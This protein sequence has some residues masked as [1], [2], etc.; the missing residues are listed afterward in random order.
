MNI[1]FT[2]AVDICGDFKTNFYTQNIAIICRISK[3]FRLAK[4]VEYNIQIG[5]QKIKNII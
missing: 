4:Y 2:T 1:D 3:L 5:L